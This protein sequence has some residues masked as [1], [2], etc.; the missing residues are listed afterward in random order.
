MVARRSLFAVLAVGSLL[1]VAACGSS[2]SSP[3]GGGSSSSSSSPSASGKTITLGEVT[4][5]SGPASVYGIA[6]NH[7][8]QVAVNQ[9]NAAGGIK[10]LGGAK[11]QIKKYDTESNPDDGQTEA[12]AAVGDKVS[13]V[14]GGEISDT[15]L[16]GI[17]V[18]QRAGIP[19]VDT[20][21]IADQIHERGYNTVFMV[22]HTTTQFIAGLPGHHPER[23][24]DPEPVQPHRRDRL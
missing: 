9:I 2:S 1:G 5:F 23:R 14:F 19:W 4:D 8:A 11:L 22:D 24:E 21:G 16:A 20:G 15:V 6:E 7:G 17:N 10:S 12:T 3:S 13:A 18:T